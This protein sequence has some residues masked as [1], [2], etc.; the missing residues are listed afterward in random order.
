M[1]N[2]GKHIMGIFSKLADEIEE[3][4]VIIA[5]GKSN[6]MD[7]TENLPV[8]HIPQSHLLTLT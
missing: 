1:E 2:Q 4:D 3:V 5:G 6:T 7:F 8:S